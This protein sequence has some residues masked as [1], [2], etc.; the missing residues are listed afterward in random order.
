MSDNRKY[1]Y[2]KLKDDFFDSDEMKV[3]ES[4][5]DGYLY[6]N[7]LLKMYL[8]SLKFDGKLMLNERIPYNDEMLASV[9][10]HNKGV[11][12]EAVKIFA[13]L[14]LI[15]VLDNGAIFIADIQNFIGQSSTE[16]DRKRAYRARIEKEKQLLELGLGQMSDYRPPEIDIDIEIEKEIELEIENKP[17]KVDD[18]PYQ[19]IVD[20]YHSITKDRLPKVKVIT[21]K[22]KTL[23]KR[24]WS[25]TGKDINVFKIIFDN[26]MADDFLSGKNG[27][28]TK[29]NYDWL[30]TFDNAIKLYERGEIKSGTTEREPTINWSDLT[31]EERE[32]INREY[33]EKYGERD[34]ER[35]RKFEEHIAQA[36]RRE[37]ER[38]DNKSDVWDSGLPY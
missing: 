17:K 5:K 4:M 8:R 12:K 25:E 35:Q 11:I 34:R 36:E 15:D 7:I 20:L 10:G 32:A 13:S 14:S 6:S 2:L 38:Q 33:E 21:D 31:D 29:C 26:L 19:E 28:W 23:T 16:G 27:K 9:T 37:R 24:I 1:Y 18:T 30:V 22:R 3:L